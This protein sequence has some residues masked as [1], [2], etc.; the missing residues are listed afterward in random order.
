VSS[1]TGM[2][3]QRKPVWKKPKKQKLKQNKTKKKTKQNK[4]P[5]ISDFLLEKL[6]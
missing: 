6:T 4:K 5:S 1:R 3:T 2:D